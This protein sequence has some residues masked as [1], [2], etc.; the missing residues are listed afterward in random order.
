MLIQVVIV[1]VADHHH[2]NGRKVFQLKPGRYQT[3]DA[4]ERK[5]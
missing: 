2:I 5:R 3:S 4:A 1:I